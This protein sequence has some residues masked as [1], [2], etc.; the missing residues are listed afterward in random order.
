MSVCSNSAVPLLGVR[1]SRGCSDGESE[2]AALSV[3]HSSTVVG[4]MY[5]KNVSKSYYIYLRRVAW[6]YTLLEA[7]ESLTRYP[8]AEKSQFQILPKKI[9]IINIA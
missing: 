8:D 4:V 3:K 5:D 9:K 2:G 1:S 7:T 6:D